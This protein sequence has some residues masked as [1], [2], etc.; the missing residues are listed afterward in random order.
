MIRRLRVHFILIIMTVVTALL[1]VILGIVLTMTARS[2]ERETVSR[3]RDLART[4][5]SR[6]SQPKAC[7][8]L[9]LCC[10]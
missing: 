2:V 4:R 3:M 8:S 10:A 9:I 1:L 6:A 5:R 7:V